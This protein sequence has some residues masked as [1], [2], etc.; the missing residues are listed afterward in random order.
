MR[1]CRC[2][3]L[4][5]LLP[6]LEMNSRA[7]QANETVSKQNKT[8]EL[9]DSGNK[10]LM[11]VTKHPWS[12]MCC[13][14]SGGKA[15]GL[16]GGHRTGSLPPAVPKAAPL[17]WGAEGREDATVRCCVPQMRGCSGTSSERCP[18]NASVAANG[19][20]LSCVSRQTRL[21][22]GPACDELSGLSS[23]PGARQGPSTP[24]T[25]LL[26]APLSRHS[27]SSARSYPPAPAPAAFYFSCA[28]KPLA[29]VPCP[30]ALSPSPPSIP[31]GCSGLRAI[32]WLLARNGYRGSLILIS[33]NCA[34]R[35]RTEVPLGSP[36]RLAGQAGVLTAWIRLFTCSGIA[37]A[38][39]PCQVFRKR[40]PQR[41]PCQPIFVCLLS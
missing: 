6:C 12:V 21:G 5:A 25:P 29:A 40:A 41:P 24:V 26:P 16:R 13:G 33:R 14:V 35:P 38:I 8:Q 18:G 23:K 3:G 17:L 7:N 36:P 10:S 19:D 22:A 4:H 34:S 15:D 37:F 39:L 9:C 11:T 28:A 2:L 20:A 30:P 31:S 1:P 27:F 32:G